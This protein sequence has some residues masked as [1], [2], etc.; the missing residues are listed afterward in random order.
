MVFPRLAASHHN[1]LRH[2]DFFWAKRASSP[3]VCIFKSILFHYLIS[4]FL[5]CTL[6]YITVWGK[7][8][9][10]LILHYAKMYFHSVLI[11]WDKLEGIVFSRD[12]DSDKNIYAH[13]EVYNGTVQNYVPELV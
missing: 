12:L 4:L 5:K 2:R 7:E 3:Y 1:Y 13:S 9:C 6:T 11:K 10:N 8:F